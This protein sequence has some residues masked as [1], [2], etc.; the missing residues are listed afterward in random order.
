MRNSRPIAQRGGW[1]AGIY[2]CSG[3][4]LL[5][6]AYMRLIHDATAWRSIVLGIAMLSVAQLL[7]KRKA[8]R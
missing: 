6:A 1:L 7:R 8:Q 5:D 3:Y 2:V 4:Y